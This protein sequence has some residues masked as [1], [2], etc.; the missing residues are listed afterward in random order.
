METN[1]RRRTPRFRLSLLPAQGK[2]DK[3][4][5]LNMLVE[6][7]VQESNRIWVLSLNGA[8][9][10]AGDSRLAQMAQ[11]MESFAPSGGESDWKDRDSAIQTRYDLFAA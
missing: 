4:Q 3:T 1:A 11:E 6:V 2:G 5:V 9:D 7:I 8:D 10:A